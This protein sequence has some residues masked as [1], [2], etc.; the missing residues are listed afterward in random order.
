MHISKQNDYFHWIKQVINDPFTALVPFCD[1][2]DENAIKSQQWKEVA[3]LVP[4]TTFW[5]TF[6]TTALSLRLVTKQKTVF[7]SLHKV[8]KLTIAIRKRPQFMTDDWLQM[9]SFKTIPAVPSQL[10]LEVKHDSIP[11]F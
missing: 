7:I 8:G 11:S 3:A 1:W 5:L 2:L 9:N 6:G 4:K 10:P